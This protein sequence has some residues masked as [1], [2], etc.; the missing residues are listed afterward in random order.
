MF[1][2]A[3]KHGAITI[4]RS[5]MDEYIALSTN[6]RR[7]CTERI[8]CGRSTSSKRHNVRSFSSSN[9]CATLHK[10]SYK[11]M[12]WTKVQEAA[13]GTDT[14]NSYWSPRAVISMHL[15]VIVYETQKRQHNNLINQGT[16]NKVGERPWTRSRSFSRTSNTCDVRVHD[17]KTIA[18]NRI[19]RWCPALS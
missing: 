17:E 2:S 7:L 19:C 3:D 4:H 12:S 16:T 10:F 8:V 14:I 15:F 9:D 6:V 5:L 18:A 11:A 1:H 13:E